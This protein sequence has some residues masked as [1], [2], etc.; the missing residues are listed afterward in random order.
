MSKNFQ[1]F[2]E[3]VFESE[4]LKNEI[5]KAKEH[6]ELKPFV[7][8]YWKLKLFVLV[9]AP[10]LSFFSIVCAFGFLY[11]QFATNLHWV[12][13]AVFAVALLIILELVKL[14]VIG[15]VFKRF[16]VG[17]LNGLTYGLL[18]FALSVFALS[19]FTSVEGAKE[20]YKHLDSSEIDLKALQAIKM[21]SID[22][23]FTKRIE[24]EKQALNDFKQSVSW[25]GKI[26]IN[27]VTVAKTIQS[28][29]SKIDSLEKDKR[30]I[31][32]ANQT[33]TQ[34]QLSELQ[35]AN[36]FNIVFWLSVSGIIEVLI[37]LCSFFKVWYW[38]GVVKENELFSGEA[39]N[40]SGFGFQDL[41]GLGNLIS[42]HAPQYLPMM[43]QNLGV[44]SILNN[45]VLQKEVNQSLGAN[46]YSR[47]ENQ[48]NLRGN[49]EN[50]L[51]NLGANLDVVKEPIKEP[52]KER[53][54][55]GLIED[56]ENGISD[57]R[58]LCPKYKINVNTLEVYRA[59]YLPNYKPKKKRK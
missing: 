52:T 43:Q 11:Y 46:T 4:K 37:L 39:P 22:K 53:D 16:F 50:G 40:A 9:C 17:S 33:Q 44:N 51:Q 10:L 18:F 47:L 8:E 20:I 42:L 3:K 36:G 45:Q 19:A 7:K 12:V 1:K 14:E 57:A 24:A 54:F 31:T 28:F 27:D 13:S 5:E 2:Y 15:K 49:Q 58:V 59:Q 21:D 34:S 35:K 32:Q 56:L 25:Q 48:E 29:T 30:I 6:F 38:F 41:Q 23:T 55:S 26:N